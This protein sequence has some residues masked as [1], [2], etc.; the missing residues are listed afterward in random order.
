M[1]K[2]VLFNNA[3]RNNLLNKRLGESKFG[4]HVKMLSN[5]NNIYEQLLNLDVEFVI[6][7]LPEDVGVFANHGNTGTSKTW[8]TTLK[9]LLNIQSNDF[10]HADQV[11]ILG[12]LDFSSE[13]KTL[14]KL[15][16]SKKKD[17]LKA[18]NLVDKID[19][20]VSHV[21]YQIILA[22][23][24]PI[25]IGGGHNNA[26]GNIKGASLA[27]GHTMNV[28]NFDA[29]SD[30]RTEEGR[31]SGNGFSYAFA[32]GFL[33]HYFVFG[34]HEN[35][36]SD[37]IFKILETSKQTKYNTFEALEVRNE[38]KFKKELNRASEFICEAPFGIEIDCDA[39]EGI[40]SSAMTPSGFSVKQTRQFLN[41]F[42]KQKKVTYLHLCEALPTKKKA[43][44]V[45]KLLTYLI[46]DFI[47]AV[48]A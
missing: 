10:T 6:I 24:K 2:L 31:H 30:F 28:I 41:H 40:Q 19:S 44:Q 37:G 25:V 27:L 47:K 11:L 16:S 5:I 23:K 15:N 18:R 36:T 3:T 35:Y 33:D 1:D 39:I 34:L 20:Y 4:Q 12:H 7:G 42:S 29:H 45:G 21:I 32:E 48:K 14:E 13:L 43:N 46:T 9:T 38:L 22:G 26:Y 17:I 8:E